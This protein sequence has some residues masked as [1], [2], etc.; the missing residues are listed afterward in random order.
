MTHLTEE[1]E[2][3][4]YYGELPP[5][6]RAHLDHCS[7]CRT[8]FERLRDVLDSI[9]DHPVPQRGASYGAEVWTRL[10]PRLPSQAPRRWW[11]R[12]WTLA[13]AVAALLVIA[14]VAGMFTQRERQTGFSAQARERVLLMA[15]SD[16]LERSQIVLAQ[17][18]HSNS[19]DLNL[20][21]ERERA[22]DLL[23]ENRLLRQTAALEGDVGH[24]ALLDD[25]ERVLLN[26]ANSPS[27]IS[28]DDLAALQQRIEDEALLFKVRITSTDA[29]Q[30]GQKL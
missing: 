20:P 10:L 6:L 17:V 27:D 7:E 8:R 2:M 14:F 30:K 28:Q 24:A 15:M 5:D 19:A 1:Q 12:T 4:A 9:R 21:D 3:T 11:L 22:R 18:L 16:H 29:R 23:S 13:P 26:I 25:L